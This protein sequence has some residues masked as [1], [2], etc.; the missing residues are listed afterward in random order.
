MTRS[1][2]KISLALAFAGLTFLASASLGEACDNKCRERQTIFICEYETCRTFELMD[3]LLCESK[4]GLCLPNTTDTRADNECGLST[5][6]TTV[7]IHVHTECMTTCG[8]GANIKNT[9]EADP[10]Y[11]ATQSFQTDHYICT[12]KT[13]S[14]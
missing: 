6:P 9:V 8:C 11:F 12:K 4:F 10:A 2:R 3:C 5:N 13:K 1:F 7:I 14:Y